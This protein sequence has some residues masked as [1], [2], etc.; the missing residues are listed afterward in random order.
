MAKSKVPRF[1]LAHSVD[2][3]SGAGGVVMP[4]KDNAENVATLRQLNQT[5]QHVEVL[6]LMIHQMTH[7]FTILRAQVTD[8]TENNIK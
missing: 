7:D 4:Q 6:E 2:G 8:V 5:R 1:L 3:G